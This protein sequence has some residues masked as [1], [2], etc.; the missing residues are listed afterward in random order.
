M[1]PPQNTIDRR[2]Q[3]GGRPTVRVDDQVC[4]HAAP[5]HS[6]S[7]LHEPHALND[8]PPQPQDYHNP[9]HDLISGCKS[10]KYRFEGVDDTTLPPKAI[11]RGLVHGTT[12]DAEIELLKPGE[13]KN[14]DGKPYDVTKKDARS[15][16]LENKT[17][18]RPTTA[19]ERKAQ[20]LANR[21][22]SPQEVHSTAATAA[23]RMTPPNS[24]LW[25]SI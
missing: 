17:N 6:P 8:D 15:K 13:G 21:R 4:W 3:L 7:H 11:F 23:G 16:F 19:V 1:D 5:V 22:Q 18:N 9:Y 12:K 25:A 10:H 2:R 24:E 14:R 20:Q